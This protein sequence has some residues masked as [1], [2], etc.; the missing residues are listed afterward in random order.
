MKPSPSSL[1]QVQG[2]N[3]KRVSFLK[4]TIIAMFAALTFTGT[5]F[6][7]S[8]ILVVDQQRVLRDSE[9]GKHVARQIQS[10]AQQMENELK[11]QATPL[12]SERDRLVAELQGLS[13]DALKNRPDLQK[14][15]QDLEVKGQ[16]TQIEAA[17][18]QREMQVTEQKAIMKIN[19]K[20]EGILEALVKERG[21][22]IILDRSLVIYGSPADITD[23]VISRLNSQLRTVSVV[24]ERIPR[25]ASN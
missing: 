7:Q 11:A 24:R 1:T 8:T 12:T 22:D 3:M 20:L 21:A 15:A 2:S 4:A 16:K 23:T 6:A 5:A 18:K 25:Q 14:R 10:I 13:V 17:Y 19:D 9:A